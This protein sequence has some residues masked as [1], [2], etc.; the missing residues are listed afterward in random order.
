[1]YYV[2]VGR[3]DSKVVYIGKGKQA[4]YLHLN[5][6]ISS[7]YQANK[8]HFAGGVTDVEII[9][10]TDSEADALELESHLIFEAK[11]IWNIVGTDAVAV[12]PNRKGKSYKKDNAKSQYYGVKASI[13]PGKPW[14]S[15]VKIGRDSKHIASHNTELEAALARDAYII[16]HSLSAIL[17]FPVDTGEEAA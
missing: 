10:R 6:G 14:R 13:G 15:W 9:Y 12:R 11:P 7:C 2:Y 8:Y 17:N 5:S 1:M 16:E 3:V 4:R